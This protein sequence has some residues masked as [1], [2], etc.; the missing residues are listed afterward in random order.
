[1]DA[2]RAQYV[3]ALGQI[4]GLEDPR[5]HDDANEVFNLERRLTMAAAQG[6]DI[7]PS[8]LLTVE[9]F[10]L[11]MDKIYVNTSQAQVGL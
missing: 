10:Q 11:E 5:F 4:S 3:H 2:Y 6:Y 1:M 7:D 8:E 9:Q